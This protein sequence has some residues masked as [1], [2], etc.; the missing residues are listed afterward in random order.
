MAFYGTGGTE[1]Q[2]KA[3]LTAPKYRPIGHDC[4]TQGT[5]GFDFNLYNQSILSISTITLAYCVWNFPDNYDRGPKVLDTHS[6]K[7]SK[8]HGT[9]EWAMNECNKNEDCT[10]LDD[11]I[12]DD[13][14]WRYCVNVD[15]ENYKDANPSTI[16]CTLLKP[17]PGILICVCFLKTFQISN[18]VLFIS[19]AVKHQI[20]LQAK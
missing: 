10:H 20:Y 14:N 5:F 3:A 15:I 12:C 9:L 19:H 11:Y 6:K 18:Y 17:I 2:M 13:K 1:D 7:C 16:S 4:N 8:E